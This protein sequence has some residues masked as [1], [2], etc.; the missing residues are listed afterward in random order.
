[1]F[2]LNRHKFFML[3]ILKD[4]YTTP[5]LAANLAFK[6]GTASSLQC[7]LWLING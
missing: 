6:G 5:L 1:M 3:Q 2:D 4:I 7:G